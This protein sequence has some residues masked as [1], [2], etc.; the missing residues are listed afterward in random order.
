MKAKPIYR[1]KLSHK[2]QCGCKTWDYYFAVHCL[3]CVECGLILVS[4][5]DRFETFDKKFYIKN[6]SISPKLTKLICI[7]DD[8]HS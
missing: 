1:Y 7:A 2:C 5:S 8:I 6:E 3:A 4:R